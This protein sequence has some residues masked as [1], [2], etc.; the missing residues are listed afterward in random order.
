[1]HA[2]LAE[3][4]ALLDKIKSGTASLGEL[5]AFAAATQQLNERAIIL[6][7]KAIEAKVY[8]SAG[9][10]AP[11]IGLESNQTEIT[12][13]KPVEIVTEQIQEIPVAQDE[14]VSSNEELSFDLFSMDEEPT[15]E[16]EAVEDTVASSMEEEEEIVDLDLEEIVD[17]PAVIEPFVSETPKME[18]PTPE[19]IIES[20]PEPV[21]SPNPTFTAPSNEHPVLRRARTND[22]SLQ[23]RLLSVRLETLKNAFGLNERMQIV[24]ELFGGD[25]DLYNQVIDELDNLNEVDSARSK[26]SNFAHQY[27]W[28]E[29]S[30]LAIEFVQKVERRYA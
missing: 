17:E 13:E 18:T 19:P 1:M 4:S 11:S 5:E 25:N 28:R 16:P 24:R 20:A 12:E 29:D 10:V 9:A 3:I 26:V 15:P 7:Y 30:E 27:G 8:S 14:E 6:K 21:S 22:G 2:L 23:S